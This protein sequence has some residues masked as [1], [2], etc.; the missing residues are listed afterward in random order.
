MNQIDLEG[1]NAIVTGGASGIGLATA[2]RLLKSG[3]RVVIWDRSVELLDK[4][5]AQLSAL[6]TVRAL[7]VDVGNCEA[8]EQAASQS[9]IQL[10]DIDILVNSAGITRQPA[11]ITD[12]P[13]R[14]WNDILAVNLNGVFFCCRAVIP[15]MIA[16]GYGRVIN[17]AS[18]AGK[19]GNARETA[20]STAK[21]GVI[22]LTKSLGKELGRTGVIVNAIAPGVLKTPMRTSRASPELVA[23]LLQRTPLGRPGDV[24]ELAATIAWMAS[25]ECSYTTGFTFDASGGRATY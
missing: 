25:E 1:R 13:L 20:Y 22:A 16:R 21:A 9:E 11:P 5:G 3:A 23:Q 19:E 15:G 4:A 8:V 24:A 14:D 7:P 6:G 18:M 17:V 10:G 2:E 12:Y